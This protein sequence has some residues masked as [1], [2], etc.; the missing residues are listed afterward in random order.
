MLLVPG[1]MEQAM[2]VYV[3]PEGLV[4]SLD[5]RLKHEVRVVG[6]HKWLKLFEHHKSLAVR[7]PR[8]FSR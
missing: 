5:S 1:M 7:S 8:E 2:S 3:H 6:Y 4:N